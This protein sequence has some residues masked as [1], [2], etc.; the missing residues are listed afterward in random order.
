[1]RASRVVVSCVAVAFAAVVA[2][3]CSSS[4]GEKESAAQ[5]LTET[6]AAT[7]PVSGVVGSQL[8]TSSA[9]VTKIDKATR[10]FTLQR[11]DG[12]TATMRAGPEVRNFDQVSEGDTVTVSYYESL[13][14]EVHKPGDAQIGAV[15]A[16]V[17]GRAK[18]G[19]MPGAGAAQSVQVTATI[20]DI[21]TAGMHV[22]LKGP[23]GGLVTVK[24]RDAEKLSRV[25]VGDLVEI[26][27]T[28]AFA[29]SVT[30]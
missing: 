20:T 10:W 4:S 5:A 24:V 18:K 23:D 30:K 11:P 9:T 22:T 28:E 3:G 1:M 15:A 29:V 8:V 7:E 17:A 19:D 27:Y 14:Y 21:D 6:V 25:A 26:T 12:R 2:G 13:A 16:G